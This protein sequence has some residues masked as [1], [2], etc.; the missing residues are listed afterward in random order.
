MEELHENDYLA[1]L[2]G[3]ENYKSLRTPFSSGYSTVTRIKKKNFRKFGFF[4]FCVVF[5]YHNF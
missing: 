1:P 4:V 3:P 5:F 2:E